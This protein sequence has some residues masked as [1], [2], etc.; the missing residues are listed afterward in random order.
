MPSRRNPV[1]SNTTILILGCGTMQVPA[2]R[3]AGEMNWYVVAAD[4]NPDAEGKNL[5]NRFLNIDLKDTGGLIDAARNIRQERGLDGVFTAGTDFSLAVALIAEALNLPGHSSEAARLATDKVAMRQRF[6]EKG[7]PSPAFVE[8]SAADDSS[9]LARRVPGPWVVKPVD[10][11]G[12]RGVIR[13]DEMA[14]LDEAL[15]EARSYSRSGRALLE[16]YMEGPEYSLDALIED[17]KLLRCGLADRYIFYPPHFIEVG[18]TIPSAVSPDI[19]DSLWT[20]FESGVKALGLTRGA[21]KGDVKLTP[22]GP[23]I[24]EIAARL[25]GGYMSGWTWP[26]ASGIEPTRGGLRLAAGLEA[27]I[28]APLRNLIC[29]ERALISIDGTIRKLDGVETAQSLPGISDVFLR[30]RP[31]DKVGFPRNNVEKVGNVIATGEDSEQAAA[32][33]SAALQTLNL[34]LDTADESTGAYL[35]GSGP[36]PPDAF[37]FEEKSDLYFSEFLRDHWDSRPARPSRGC[38]RRKPVVM[39]PV[40]VAAADLAGR[41]IPDVLAILAGEGLLIIGEEIAPDNLPRTSVGH[42]VGSEVLQVRSDFWKALVR[43][44]LAGARWYLEK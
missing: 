35:D 19:A 23:M 1:G 41:T 32:R 43:G 28:G 22:A 27:E 16:T 33:A 9:D 29:A 18:H 6:M 25:S 2:L 38:S 44:G 14:S 24:G 26:A 8:V 12:A 11:M 3:I 17:G 31:G 10:S 42:K 39:N 20:A 15:A 5:C 34:E 7:V 21:A 37:S 36:F 13:I 30:Y 4:G 40:S